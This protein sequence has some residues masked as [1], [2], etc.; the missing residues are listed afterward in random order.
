MGQS[1]WSTPSRDDWKLYNPMMLPICTEILDSL[2][3]YIHL[4]DDFEYEPS[5][6][7]DELEWRLICIEEV[8]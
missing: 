2:D 3:G 7:P 5:L 4:L 1:R 8:P 6:L